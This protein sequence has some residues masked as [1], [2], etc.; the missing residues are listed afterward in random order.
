[1]IFYYIGPT[2]LIEEISDGQKKLDSNLIVSGLW[3]HGY[4]DKTDGYS[5]HF[6]YNFNVFVMMQIFNF[7]NSRKIEDEC[8]MF[9]GMTCGSYFTII[10]IV[11]FLLQAVIVTVGTKAFMCCTWGVGPLGWLICIG[12]GAVS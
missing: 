5:R 9:E 2:F 7:I 3:D 10:V 12:V 1:M 8:N 4:D 11:I 6:T